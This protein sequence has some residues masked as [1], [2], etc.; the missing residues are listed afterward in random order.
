M[1]VQHV[2]VCPC[3]VLHLGIPVFVMRDY[4]QVR[5]WHDHHR[6]VCGGWCGAPHPSYPAMCHA[7][8]YETCMSSSIATASAEA[9]Q[10]RC[11]GMPG[12]NTQLCGWACSTSACASLY[13]ASSATALQPDAPLS[14]LLPS[15][16]CHVFASQPQHVPAH[17]CSLAWPLSGVSG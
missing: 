1:A 2:A 6:L 14:L 17:P 15:C 8:A 11:H 9:A 3:A 13:L 12:R 5:C 16:C 4:Y 7:T 10:R